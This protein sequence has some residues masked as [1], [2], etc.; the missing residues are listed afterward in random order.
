MAKKAFKVVRLTNGIKVGTKLPKQYYG[1]IGFKAEDMLL[2]N[3]YTMSSGSEPDIAALGLEV[4]TRN[5]AATS[6]QTIATMTLNR[7]IAT[8]YENSPICAKIQQQYRIKYDNDISEVTSAEVYDFSDPIIQG[9]IKLGYETARSEISA[10]NKSKYICGTAGIGYFEKKSNS[11]NS[12]GFRI[13][14]SCMKNLE[15]Q[16]QTTKKFAHIFDCDQKSS[17]IGVALPVSVGSKKSR[18]RA[19]I[20]AEINSTLFS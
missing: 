19:E 5:E 15:N 9:K 16:S 4:K 7:I 12:Y 8:P 13:S 6:A 11:D 18:K 17:I 14:D 1:N 20:S 10:G 2:E 3:G